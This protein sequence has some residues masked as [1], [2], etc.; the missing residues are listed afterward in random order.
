MQLLNPAG[1]L[2]LLPL[3][4]LKL[5]FAGA[6]G[7]L[8][9]LLRRRLHLAQLRVLQGLPCPESAG[10]LSLSCPRLSHFDRRIAIR[11]DGAIAAK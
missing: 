8:L 10:V 7:L 5:L 4:L 3:V 2:R 6:W 11:R 1:T 9:R